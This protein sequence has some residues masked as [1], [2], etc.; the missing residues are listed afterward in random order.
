MSWLGHVSPPRLGHVFSPKLLFL[1]DFLLFMLGKNVYFVQIYRLKCSKQG[2]ATYNC[3][4]D[5]G[6]SIDHY[7]TFPSTEVPGPQCNNE[8]LM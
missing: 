1:L 5:V 6:G 4:V 3:N 7:T 2:L 8:K